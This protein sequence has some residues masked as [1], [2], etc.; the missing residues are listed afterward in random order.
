[1]GTERRTFELQIDGMMCINCQ[2]KVQKALL[3][4]PGI[5]SADVDFEAGTAKII[6]DEGLTAPKGIAAVV[7]ELGFH[8]IGATA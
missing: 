3:A 5:E 4:S 2:N 1:M 8:V 6:Y 7:D